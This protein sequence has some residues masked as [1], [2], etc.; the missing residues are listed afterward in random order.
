MDPQWCYEHY[1]SHRSL[2]S[3]DNVR[4]QL[5]RVMERN[6]LEMMSTPFEDPTYYTNI[7]R[8]LTVGFFMQ[9]AKKAQ[10]AKHYVT[11]KDQQVVSLHPSTVL[12]TLPEWVI[13]NEY[14]FHCWIFIDCRFVLTTKNFIRT[15]TN[16]KPEWLLEIADAYYDLTDEKAF[17]KNS[18][19][20]IGLTAVVNRMNKQ[21]E[22]AKRKA[23]LSNGRA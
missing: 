8:A 6:D 14:V 21:R 1:L 15:I 13:Y 9:V 19:V 22:L 11:V 10:G 18:D 7:R 3:A 5:K 12:E 23:A 20:K 4:A 17:P 16:I 2:L